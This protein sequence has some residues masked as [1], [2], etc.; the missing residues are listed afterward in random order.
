M[1]L[2]APNEVPDFINFY[3]EAVALVAF[4]LYPILSFIVIGIAYIK[5]K[6]SQ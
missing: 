1:Y 4:I 2:I 5:Q 3:K 6:K